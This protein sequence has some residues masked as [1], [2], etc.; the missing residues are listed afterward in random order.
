MI[1][2]VKLLNI[3]INMLILLYIQGLKRQQI[4]KNYGKSDGDGDED[5]SDNEFDEDQENVIRIDSCIQIP[6]K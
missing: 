3:Y 5:D 4:S 6:G 1:L 2:K